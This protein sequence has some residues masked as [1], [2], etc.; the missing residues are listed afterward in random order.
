MSLFG[1][2]LS[3][4]PGMGFNT[5]TCVD[6]DIASESDTVGSIVGDM[7]RVILAGKLLQVYVPCGFKSRF[8]VVI[9]RSSLRIS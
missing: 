3:K 5:S 8:F 9:L 7:V 2:S 6:N 1:F 4:D